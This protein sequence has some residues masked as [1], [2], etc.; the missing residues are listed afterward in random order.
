VR[1]ENNLE[2]FR[3]LEIRTDSDSG[4]TNKFLQLGCHCDKAHSSCVISASD[5]QYTNSERVRGN[6]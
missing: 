2:M 6:A 3:R 5:V 1:F 4:M